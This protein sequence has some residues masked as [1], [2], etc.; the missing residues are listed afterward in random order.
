MLQTFPFCICTGPCK[1]NMPLKW[2]TGRTAGREDAL[3]YPI[4]EK[5]CN[6][7]GVQGQKAVMEAECKRRN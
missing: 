4:E 1:G 7:G 5:S 2:R 3:P 6:R